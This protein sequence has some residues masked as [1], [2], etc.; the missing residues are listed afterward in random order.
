MPQ[1]KVCSGS[2]IIIFEKWPHVTLIYEF[3]VENSWN[4]QNMQNVAVFRLILGF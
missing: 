1:K 4:F 2:K 3:D